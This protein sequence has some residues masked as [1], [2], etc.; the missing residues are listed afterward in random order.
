MG[1]FA[2]PQDKTEWEVI[3]DNFSIL[4]SPCCNQV[5]W[6]KQSGETELFTATGGF[7]AEYPI[8]QSSTNSSIKLWW[9]WHGAFGHWVVN[10]TPGEHHQISGVPQD[11]LQS[12]MAL[13]GCPNNVRTWINPR[14]GY[15]AY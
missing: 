2:C 4:A 13:D 5:Y 3:A 8:Y 9:M 11:Q 6:K 14:S 1:D 12:M 7:N 15:A 10:P